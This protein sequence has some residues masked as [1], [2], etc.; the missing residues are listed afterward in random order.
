[1][2]KRQ[3]SRSA[4]VEEFLAAARLAPYVRAHLPAAEREACL[5]AHAAVLA[6]TSAASGLELR[7]ERLTFPRDVC[8]VAIAAIEAYASQL[9]DLFGDGA[10]AAW[11]AEPYAE[12][13]LWRRAAGVPA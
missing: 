13:I 4:A 3:A 8:R 10:V 9:A 6:G 7:R 12:H 1:M 5:R 2:Y 11:F